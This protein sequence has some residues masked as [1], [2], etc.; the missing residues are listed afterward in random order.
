MI[1]CH[2]CQKILAHIYIGCDHNL[3]AAAE[4]KDMD[5]Q[6]ERMQ[7]QIDELKREL[8]DTTV[9]LDDLSETYEEL[10][11]QKERLKVPSVTDAHLHRADEPK[12]GLQPH[13]CELG[14]G[15]MSTL[16]G[17]AVTLDQEAA[18]AL[19]A[20]ARHGLTDL[21]EVCCACDSAL[22]GQVL[23]SGGSTERYSHWNGYDLTTSMKGM[24]EIQKN[25][26]IAGSGL[27]SCPSCGCRYE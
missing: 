8:K 2:D 7:K 1:R 12:D 3:L 16:M 26:T 10:E 17:A 9:A 23:R 24:A 19:V 5:I 15:S 6:R 20:A 13:V 25:T 27:W 4:I 18:K 11:V 22:A 14:R 21:V